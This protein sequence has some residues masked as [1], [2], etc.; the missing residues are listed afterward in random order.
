MNPARDET[1]LRLADAAWAARL[2][3][4]DPHGLQAVVLRARAGPL[5]DRWLALLRA[6]LPP[7]APF[8][9]LPPGSDTDR[10]TGGLDLE[11]TLAAGRP[12]PAA[13]LL[14]EAD[15]GI[16]VVPMAE[17]LAATHAA[18][19]AAVLDAGA[20]HLERHGLSCRRPARLGLVLL[21][22]GDEPV[23]AILAERAAL[24]LD[25]EGFRANAPLEPDALDALG[26]DVSLAEAAAALTEAAAACGI[27]SLRPALMALRL[28]RLAAR[29]GGLRRGHLERVARLVLAPR[30]QRRPEPAQESPPPRPPADG[31]DKEGRPLPDLL[32]EAVA[33]ALPPGLL[34]AFAAKAQGRSAGGDPARGRARAGLRGRP[35]G[36][37]PG[38]PG[39][40]RRL[41]LSDTLQA[42]APWQRLRAPPRPPLRFRLHRDDLR[43]QRVE[44]PAATT[45]V[46]V[47]DASGSAAAERLAEA[48][49]AA[50]WLL[51]ESY[52]R[53]TEVAVVAF[54]GQEAQLLL[55]PTRSLTRA[56][57]AIAGL[58]GGGGTPLAAGL[59]LARRLA[60]AERRRGRTPLVVALTD[61]RANVA[62]DGRTGREP[63]RADAWRVAAL[64][65]AEGVATTVIDIS[66][67]PRPEAA[68]L[69]AAL[70][71][72]HLA[73]PR[74]EPH[75]IAAAL[76]ED[77]G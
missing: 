27:A 66:A 63:A 42:A 8:R 76:R 13:G 73:L 62:L 17:R 51:A 6:T 16:L 20:I 47:V 68:E 33:T 58:P 69:A 52:V 12:V 77:R 29:G 55:P 34:S 60:A 7:G 70:G 46:L 74:A 39:N 48:K 24:W 28:A 15:G 1:A 22:E 50:E 14:A 61:G 30:A 45:A 43:I 72:R 71:A 2:F 5:R 10:L 38:L 44:P 67:R 21:A 53:R 4:R 18:L 41:A 40:G 9:R 31:A 49:G 11:A 56:R 75:R 59:E 65:R 37:R 23:P 26:P 57:R 36:S 25:L 64:L 19:L 3:A 32:V 35:A 54:R